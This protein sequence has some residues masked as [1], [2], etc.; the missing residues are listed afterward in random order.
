MNQGNQSDVARLRKQLND[1]CES[2]R[3]GLQGL[4]AG[5]S[6]H[7]FLREKM[8]RLGQIASDLQK[9]VGPD[10]AIRILSEANE[11]LSG[12]EPKGGTSER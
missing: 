5:T 9:I 12:Q 7:E 10:E 1:E 11:K 8:N 4:A 2:A 3:L 6:K